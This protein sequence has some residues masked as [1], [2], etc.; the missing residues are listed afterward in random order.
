MGSIDQCE[1]LNN[2][3][4]GNSLAVGFCKTEEVAGEKKDRL[5]RSS[6]RDVNADKYSF[7]LASLLASHLQAPDSDKFQGE[8][9]IS[10]SHPAMFL[11]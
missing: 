5:V 4:L 9:A 8:A 11:H 3:H 6:G 2:A 7:R 10:Q 1:L